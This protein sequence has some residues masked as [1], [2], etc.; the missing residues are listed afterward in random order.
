MSEYNT[1]RNKLIIREYGRNVQQMVEKLLLVED[2]QKRTEGA[3]AVV[4]AMAQLSPEPKGSRQSSTLDYWHKLWDHLFII[5]D[6]RLDV[7][8]P[9]PKPVRQ[10]KVIEVP[11]NHYRK[12][13]IENR[14][15]GR[16]M[17][18]VIKTV[19]DYPDSPQK[20]MLT[21]SIANYL[22]KLYLIWN[23][24][25]VDDQLIFQQ[26]R[27]MSGGKLVVEEDFKLANTRDIL[28]QN[29]TKKTNGKNNSKRKKRKKNKQQ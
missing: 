24:D 17:A 9:F 19:A 8:A 28:I 7:D 18:Q 1:S 23:R 6:Y 15:Y 3:K 29:Q 5:S 13:K 26:L 27:E 20:K 10:E 11:E 14:V 22:K 2:Y 4:K 12:D 16:N 21:R 25:S